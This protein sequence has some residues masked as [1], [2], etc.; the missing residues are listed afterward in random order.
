[1]SESQTDLGMHNK[2]LKEIKTVKYCY[3]FCVTA[4]YSPCGVFL[5]EGV[6]YTKVAFIQTISPMNCVR[7]IA[8]KVFR[9]TP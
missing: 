5:F 4:I 2:N 3:T 7:Y 9:N 6:Q 8:Q 1:M